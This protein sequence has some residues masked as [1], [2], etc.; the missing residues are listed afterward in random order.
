VVFMLGF[1]ATAVQFF[2]GHDP[3][4]V[5]AGLAFAAYAAAFTLGVP[6]LT[7]TPYQD[8]DAGRCW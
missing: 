7:L 8:L 6:A 3:D 2:A 4:P 1:I 5:L